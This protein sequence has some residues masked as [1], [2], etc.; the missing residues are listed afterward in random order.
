MFLRLL[1]PEY[2]KIFFSVLPPSP[3]FSSYSRVINFAKSRE[4]RVGSGGGLLKNPCP[5]P[6]PPSQVG[7]VWAGLTVRVGG[8]GRRRMKN[9][10]RLFLQLPLTRFALSNRENW[11]SGPGAPDSPRLKHFVH[12]CETST[13]NHKPL[14]SFNHRYKV[15]ASLTVNRRL[16]VNHSQPYLPDI[17]RKRLIF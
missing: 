13:S 1:K 11:K 9:G 12:S 2:K 16:T 10:H 7:Q 3:V 8:G 6:F 5:P 17:L 14:S 15:K 4:G